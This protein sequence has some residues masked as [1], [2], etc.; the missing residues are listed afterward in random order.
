MQSSPNLPAEAP[1]MP[2]ATP[3]NTQPG[4]PSMGQDLEQFLRG[5]M[6]L[7]EAQLCS[8]NSEVK[9]LQ[10]RMQRYEGHM[11]ITPSE[12]R[13]SLYSKTNP[14]KASELRHVVLSPADVRKVIYFP[15]NDLFSY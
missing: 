11:S 9:L 5:R 10:N 14:I 1:Y 15:N 13:P 6:N 8:Y 2:Y 4:A 12:I 3:P 7:L